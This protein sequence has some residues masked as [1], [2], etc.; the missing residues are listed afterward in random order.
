MAAGAA[1]LPASIPRHN[2]PFLNESLFS[3]STGRHRLTTALYTTYGLDARECVYFVGF[4]LFILCLCVP[5]VWIRQSL[6]SSTAHTIVYNQNYTKEQLLYVFIGLLD[7]F[8]LLFFSRAI[9]SL[10]Y[11]RFTNVMKEGHSLFLQLAGAAHPS[12]VCLRFRRFLFFIFLFIIQGW[13]W[14][15]AQIRTWPT[16]RFWVLLFC[17]RVSYSFKLICLRVPVIKLPLRSSPNS[18][19]IMSEC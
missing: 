11:F 13:N 3:G 8:L 14:R 7:C 18:K 16:V 6:N 9:D 5:S 4:V 12:G 17:G 1:N 15:S 10:G 2:E 19:L